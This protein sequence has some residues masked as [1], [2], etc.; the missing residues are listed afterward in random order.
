[1]TEE[2]L[3]E[4]RVRATLDDVP[5][6]SGHLLPTALARAATMRQRRRWRD[7]LPVVRLVPA[8]AGA[9]VIVVAV[10]A[11]PGLWTATLPAP[12]DGPAAG[13]WSGL[14]RLPGG[15]WSYGSST[16][17]LDGRVLILGFDDGAMR[18]QLWDPTTEA[19]TDAGTVDG[20]TR[21]SHSATLLPD[22]RVLIAGGLHGSYGDGPIG[23][24]MTW[25]PAT[26]A[27]APTGSLVTRRSGHLAVGLD[28]RRVLVFGGN[29]DRTAETYQHQGRAMGFRALDVRS[30]LDGFATA[31]RLADGRVLVLGWAPDGRCTEIWD[32]A[33][34][35]VVSER[36]EGGCEARSA[37]SLADGRVL[38]T[39]SV[40]VDGG[41]A[42]GPEPGTSAALFD[43]TRGAFVPAGS[44]TGMVGESVAVGLADGRVLVAGGHGPDGLTTSAAAIWDPGTSSFT[45]VGPMTTAR[46]DPD[47]TLLDDGRVLV[48]GGWDVDVDPDGSGSYSAISS[49]EVFDPR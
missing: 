35:V 9:V 10:V 18:A 30:E 24:A 19:I 45:A 21:E 22:G 47:A 1:M 3:L 14:T 13:A 26:G 46:S 43:P 29:G 2:M 27:F 8:I 17:L 44:M 20:D 42:G 32:P 6:V 49:L 41:V 40:P 28:G 34:E 31:A 16:R 37:T 25:D 11:V 4:R 38:V 39:T 33:S 23:T 12:G 48:V 15:N 36:I 5:R 7:R